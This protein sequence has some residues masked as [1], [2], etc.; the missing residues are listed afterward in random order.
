MLW[1]N[2]KSDA[3]SPTRGREKSP[4]IIAA[5]LHVL[6]NITSEGQ[7]DFAGS[8]NGNIQCQTLT[9]R[10]QGVVNG[11]VVADTVIVYGRINGLIRARH[12]HLH[13]TS[14]IEGIVMHESITIEDGAYIDGKCKRSDKLPPAPVREEIPPMPFFTEEPEEAAPAAEVKILKNIRLISG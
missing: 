12:V 4:S 7:L 3:G 1:K 2:K 13:S 11:E 8:I 6:G 9:V 14:H 10:A 5:D